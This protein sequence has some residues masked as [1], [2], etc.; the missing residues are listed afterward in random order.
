MVIRDKIFSIITSVFKRHGAV[1]IDTSVFHSARNYVEK[2]T[3]DIPA[4]PCLNSKK[5]SPANT[6]RTANSFTT[7]QTKAVNYAHSATT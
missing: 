6:A 1:T 7:S 3:I 5:S 4:D 2:P